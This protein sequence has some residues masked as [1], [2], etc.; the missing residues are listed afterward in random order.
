VRVIEM[1]TDLVTA[2]RHFDL[3]VSNGE[4]K[5]NPDRAFARSPPWTAPTLPAGCS[6]A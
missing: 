2:E 1:V 4:L 3:P 5:A 6:P